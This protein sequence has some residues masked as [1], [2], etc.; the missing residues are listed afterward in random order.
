MRAIHAVRELN[1]ERD[2]PIRVIALYTE[3]ERHALFVRQADERHCLG[4]AMT[5][6]R[7]RVPRLRAARARAGR[8]GRPTRPGSA[9]A[10]WPSIPPS[11]SCAS[12]S[13]SS[14][15]A[16]TPASCARWAT[17]SR[18]SAWPRRPACRSQRG[19]A[20]PSRASRTP[21]GRASMRLKPAGTFGHRG[22]SPTRHRPAEA[23][24]VPPP[25]TFT[26]IFFAPLTTCCDE[27]RAFLTRQGCQVQGYLIGRPAPIAHYRH[28]VA[29]LAGARENIAGVR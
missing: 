15:S 1:D 14:S 26:R 12:G 10:S 16:L 9:G 13:G 24:D 2:D 5:E 21:S 25:Q 23:H 17:R 22:V 11:P 29:G 28:L 4:P 20:A 6:D 27:Q 3:T 18:P 8:D 19:A 7:Q